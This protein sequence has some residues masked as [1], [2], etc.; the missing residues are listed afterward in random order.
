MVWELQT[1]VKGGTLEGL[2]GK[3]ARVCGNQRS[4]GL[5]VGSGEMEPF[6]SW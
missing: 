1:G 2:S 6:L 3:I 4:Q 5:V